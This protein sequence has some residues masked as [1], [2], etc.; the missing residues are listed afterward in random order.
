MHLC[1]Y[2][3]WQLWACAWGYTIL[4]T[5]GTQ[6]WALVHTLMYTMYTIL[7]HGYTFL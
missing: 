5:W 7:Y 4:Y 1:L 2:V 6:F 3:V